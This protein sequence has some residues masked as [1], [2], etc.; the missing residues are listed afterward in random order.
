M[1]Q[2]SLP[3]SRPPARPQSRQA[4]QLP[5]RLTEELRYLERRIRALSVL[6][7]LSIAILAT[8]AV[9][10]VAFGL[11]Y[12]FDLSTSSRWVA[13]GTLTATGVGFGLFGLRRLLFRVPLPE[14]AAAV[15]EKHPEFG[16]RLLSLVEFSQTEV[17][18]R[19][20]GS[21]MMRT[22][23][24]RE[25][26]RLVTPA[27]F[28]AVVDHSRASKR[29]LAACVA[30]GLLLFPSLMWKDSSRL[31]WARLLTPWNN[32]ER[33]SNLFFEVPNGDRVAPRGEDVKLVAIA[34]WRNQKPEPIQEVRL[35]WAFDGAG[36]ESRRMAWDEAANAYSTSL[37]AIQRGFRLFGLGSECEVTE[38]PD[39][40]R[41]PTRHHLSE[42]RTSTALLYR[43][44]R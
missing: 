40:S 9:V 42:H 5:P 22:L 25:T 44:P 28:T 15:E 36:I 33:P 34:G 23:L 35:N 6:S 21:A 7:G 4:A 38:V 13:L 43:T 3:G 39:P 19:D 10:L 12:W 2:A 16:E 8:V 11:D 24:E 18:E 17:E 20:K 32:F 26:L 37:P 14:L 29:V 41:G 30:I 1:A 31:L 27:D